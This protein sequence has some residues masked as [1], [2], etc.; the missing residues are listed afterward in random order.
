MDGKPCPL[1]HDVQMLMDGEAARAL[2]EL[3]R[4]RWGSAT[5]DPLSPPCL[6]PVGDHWPPS[7]RPDFQHVPS[8]LPVL[9][10]DT[11]IARKSEMSKRYSSN[12][13]NR[14]TGPFTSKLNTSRRV[15]SR[16]R[17][18]IACEILED[19]RSSS[20]CIPT[21]TAGWN[22]IQWMYCAG[23]CLSG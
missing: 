14:R 17:C 6:E 18:Q 8:R 5:G 10:R 15:A 20:C 3:A 11:R 22:S 2:G 9:D 23:G 1:F 21:A 7:V 12:Q 4:V 13:S 19:R 16:Q